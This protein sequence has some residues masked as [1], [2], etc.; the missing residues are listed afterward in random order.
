MAQL[1]D[2]FNK[3]LLFSTSATSRALSKIADQ[4]FKA[5]ELSPTQGYIMIAVR[6]APG[7]NVS[8]LSA[9]LALDPSTITKALEKMTLKGL[10]QR[11]TIGKNVRVFLTTKGE[12][13]EADAQAAWKKA[14]LSYTILLGEPAVRTL[15]EGLATAQDQLE[16][17]A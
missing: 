1:K 2:T 12:K 4:H 11:E 9:V 3:C 8:D 5:V 15:C 6:K 7:I 17:H 13:R 14:Q 16:G 10:V